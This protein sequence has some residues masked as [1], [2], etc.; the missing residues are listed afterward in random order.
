MNRTLF[1]AD[2]RSSWKFVLGVTLFILMYVSISVAMY[3]PTSAEKM[4]D[5]FE[6]FPE[7]FM[8]AFGF[9]NLGSELTSYLS[10]YLYGFIM[11]VFPMIASIVLGNSLVA[12]HVD[13]GSM[14]YLLATPNTRVKIIMTQAIYL[15]CS[16]LFIYIVNVA[17]GILL[18]ISKWSG[19][20]D[21]SKYLQLN[22]VT[23]LVSMVVSSICFLASCI[24]NDTKTSLG[25]G[26]G[27]SIFMFA[28]KMISEISEK[29]VNLKYVSIFSFI[30]IER[31]LT[32]DTS[33][34]LVTSALLLGITVVLL[35]TSVMYFNKKS[36]VI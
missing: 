22:L 9:D 6:M 7:G 1:R 19:M 36:L 11:L 26:A 29:V 2:F 13:S 5:M 25:V 34:V 20:L 28:A 27:I 12:K 18:C 31:I 35:G 30:D 33:F 32:G 16:M 23:F 4:K 17:A 24:F 21:I 8:K 10:N 15:T 3:D 14:A